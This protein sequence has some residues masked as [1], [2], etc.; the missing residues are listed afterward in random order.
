MSY[1]KGIDE[2][3]KWNPWHWYYRNH[4]TVLPK[5]GQPEDFLNTTAPSR[6]ASRPT[7]EFLCKNC[8]H[9]V[10]ISL[11][12]KKMIVLRNVTSPVRAVATCVYR[13]LIWQ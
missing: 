9:F 3:M 5:G 8:E 13:E 2:T 11:I 7:G 1:L 10:K 4:V 6:S 12:V